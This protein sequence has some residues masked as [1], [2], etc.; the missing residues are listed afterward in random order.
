MLAIA[1]AMVE[2]DPRAEMRLAMHCHACQHSWSTIFDIVSFFWT[3]IEASAKRLLREVHTLAK[4]YGW[5]EA[6]ILAL[7]SAR[8]QCYLELVS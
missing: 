6:D 4:A 7:S 2:H 1:E 5:R 8:R 3:E